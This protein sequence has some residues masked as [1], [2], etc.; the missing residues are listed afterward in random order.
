[1][2]TSPADY[3]ITVRRG[4]TWSQTF[5]CPDFPIDLTT[6]TALLTVREYTSADYPA[7]IQLTDGE[8]IDLAADEFTI[9]FSTSDTDIEPKGYF[10]DLWF[11]VGGESYPVFDSKFVVNPSPSNV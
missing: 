10:Y 4:Q 1:M 2:F 8:G 6:A 11:S 9:T 5:T 3:K 7:V